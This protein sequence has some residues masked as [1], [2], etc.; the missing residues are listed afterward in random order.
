MTA[1]IIPAT[2]TSVPSTPDQAAHLL[3]THV[4]FG[5]DA[6]MQS[7]PLR[8]E[9]LDGGINAFYVRILSGDRSA[10]TDQYIDPLTNLP[11]GVSVDAQLNLHFDGDHPAYQQLSQYEQLKFELDVSILSSTLNPA[12]HK[13]QL[14]LQGAGAVQMQEHQT[15]I[16]GRLPV[17]RDQTLLFNG[18]PILFDRI[19]ELGR[20]V[21]G[22]LE[23]SDQQV[24]GLIWPER[25]V[26]SDSYVIHQATAG[27]TITVSTGEVQ[28]GLQYA[29]LSVYGSDGS[30]W[31]SDEGIGDHQISFVAAENTTY[32]IRISGD[33]PRRVGAYQLHLSSSAQ[34][35]TLAEWPYQWLSTTDYGVLE[36]HQDGRYTYYFN[37]NAQSIAQGQSLTNSFNLSVQQASGAITPLP[38]NFDIHGVDDPAVLQTNQVSFHVSPVYS[39]VP[40]SAMLSYIDTDGGQQNVFR[41]V[42]S[43]DFGNH[44][45]IDP[46]T[47]LPYGL[48]IHQDGSYTFEHSRYQ[49]MFNGDRLTFELMVEVSNQQS[50]HTYPLTIQMV[51]QS[52]PGHLEGQVSVGLQVLING[53]F[54]D[55]S[56]QDALMS[57]GLGLFSLNAQGQYTHRLYPETQYDV[58]ESPS[59]TI[60]HIAIEQVSTSPVTPIDVYVVYGSFADD[61]LQ[62][63]DG[64]DHVYG[65]QGNDVIHGGLRSDRLYGGEDHDQL[66]GDQGNDDL[67]GGTGQDRIEGGSG[68]DTIWAGGDEDTVYAGSGMDVVYGGEGNDWVSAGIGTDTVYGDAGDDQLYGDTGIDQLYGGLDQDQLFGGGGQD[69]LSG[70]EGHDLL[71]GDSGRDV[72]RGDVGDDRLYGGDDQDQLYG[73]S[74]NDALYGGAGTD[75]LSGSSG[76]DQLYGNLDDDS[77]VG[78]SGGDQLYGGAGHDVLNGGS[79]VDRLE[80]GSGDDQL[81]GGIGTDTLFGGSGADRL[82]GGQGFDHLY[83]GRG[84][85]TY[86]FARGFRHDVIADHDS[87]PDT[88]QFGAEIRFDQ[89][90]FS[91][92]SD[93]L[94]IRVIGSRDDSIAIMDWYKGAAY[95]LESIRAG[96]GRLL[97]QQDVQTLVDAM[98]AFVLTAE[99]QQQM[100]LD[101]LT[102]QA[103]HP[104]FVV[105]Q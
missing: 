37:A 13:L 80:G 85:D 28:W 70:G 17:E 97:Q 49:P 53:E 86:E 96:D 4:S 98:A 91:R 16:T 21:S 24:D 40:Q 6:G 66:Y 62:Q 69:T 35:A 100:Q 75:Q 48:L 9:D 30:F 50:S 78:G 76:A 92:I 82:V 46:A 89:L 44:A 83:G 31:Q 14:T 57:T 22:K 74:G 101:D 27:E 65:G 15:A 19:T 12:T 103:L 5:K 63:R 39:G 43:K 87:D 77:L 10:L 95:Q 68:A 38:L 20:T 26:L 3:T 11:F 45:Y 84:A 61:T 79:G 64:Y 72:L 90:W 56:Q 33:H 42:V 23:F 94:L 67:A 52:M 59:V 55:L 93:N 60:A 81:I 7:T 88:L 41:A 54:F 102:Q 36:L 18:Q 47:S 1:V 58:N 34:T 51:G 8:Y 32:S 73:Q 29:T 104:A 99:K 2:N 105:W 25:Q 71:S